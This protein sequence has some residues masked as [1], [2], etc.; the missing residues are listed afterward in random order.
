MSKVVPREDRPLH[1]YKHSLKEHDKI[2][3]VTGEGT[4]IAPLHGRV[5]RWKEM[6]VDEHAN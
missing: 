5:K 4:Q 2:L 6:E 3:R 1:F